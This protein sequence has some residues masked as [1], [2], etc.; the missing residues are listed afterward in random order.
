MKQ[1]YNMDWLLAAAIRA[2]K[3]M[4]QTALSMISIGAAISDIQWSYV[5]SVTL[6]SGVYSLL[7]SLATNLPE[8]GT[9]GVINIDTTKPDKDAY[10]LEVNDLTALNSKKRAHFVVNTKTRR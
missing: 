10:L 5:A 4:A 1:K 6:V 8:V 2:I 9:D 7:T 3:T